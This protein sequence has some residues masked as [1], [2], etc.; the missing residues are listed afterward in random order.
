VPALYLVLDDVA[1]FIKHRGKPATDEFDEIE[2][3]D[4]VRFSDDGIVM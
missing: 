2:D 1:Q 4:N 3:E